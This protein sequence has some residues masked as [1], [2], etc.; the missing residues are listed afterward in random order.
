MLIRGQ[1]LSNKVVYVDEDQEIPFTPSDQSKAKV[2]STQFMT[3]ICGADYVNSLIKQRC[4]YLFC[5]LVP[6][7]SW[8]FGRGRDNAPHI[9]CPEMYLLSVRIFELYLIIRS[10]NVN[11]LALIRVGSW[12]KVMYVVCLPMFLWPYC[13]LQGTR[14]T[15]GRRGF[16]TTPRVHHTIF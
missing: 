2:I 13:P 16:E 11:H 8:S 12:N 10:R 15:D 5:N 1:Y 14:Q 6:I 3:C 7:M 9:L 4:G